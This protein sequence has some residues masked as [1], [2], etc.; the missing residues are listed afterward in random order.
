M[1]TQD[2]CIFCAIANGEIPTNLLYEDE[3][4][5]AFSDLNPLA[6]VH[7]LVVPKQ[8]YDNIIDG[9]PAETLAAMVHAVD[10]VA[11]DAG[12]AESGFR[13]IANTG[14][15]AG[16]TVNHLHWHVLGGARLSDELT[17][18]EE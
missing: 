4:V 9:V 11:H 2:S 5:A 8:H 3:L 17:I 14:P 1:A 15:H 10:I 7:I 13:L 12:I 18:I 6:P 16:Q